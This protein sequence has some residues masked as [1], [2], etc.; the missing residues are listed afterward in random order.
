LRLIKNNSIP[1]NKIN[2]KIAKNGDVSPLSL[3]TKYEITSA[4]NK[5]PRRELFNKNVTS[6]KIS[7]NRSIIPGIKTDN[8][9]FS[10]GS[11]EDG[12]KFSTKYPSPTKLKIKTIKSQNG[13]LF[14][15]IA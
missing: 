12:E 5:N 2:N 10:T 15:R 14:P 8:S 4:A 1:P 7:K 11:C 3:K 6:E 13:R 9:R